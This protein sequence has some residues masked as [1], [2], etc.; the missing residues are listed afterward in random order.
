MRS[1]KKR[2]ISMLLV[3]YHWRFVLYQFFLRIAIKKQHF[4]ESFPGPRY[5]QCPNEVKLL[6]AVISS[7]VKRRL[8]RRKKLLTFGRWRRMVPLFSNGKK[9]KA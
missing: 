3:S 4:K 5:S 2:N 7:S 6:S 1:E 8:W 9:R